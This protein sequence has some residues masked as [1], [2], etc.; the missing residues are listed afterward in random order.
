MTLE[1]MVSCGSAAQETRSVGE[2]L[3]LL[4][5]DAR[6]Q[7]CLT[8]GVYESAKLMNVDPDSVVLC[9]L[10][11]DDEEDI[12][13]QIHFTLIQAFCCDNDINIVRVC[14]LQKLS[15]ILGELGDDNL[16]PRDLHCILV[17]SPR[18]ESLQSEGLEKVAGYCEE[19]R[20]RNQ[21]VPCVSLL[22]R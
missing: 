12:A 18:M 9:L 17:T 6:R 7:D 21:W 1:E 15:E 16:E 22:E 5:G 13:L 14:G 3:E 11:I 2:A 19:C 8:V 20:C 10:A 4:L